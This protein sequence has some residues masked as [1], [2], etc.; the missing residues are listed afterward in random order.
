VIT[1]KKGTRAHTRRQKAKGTREKG[2][3]ALVVGLIAHGKRKKFVK[4]DEYCLLN[5][6]SFA[7]PIRAF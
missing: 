7:F 3:K 4:I 1:Y 6:T 2:I 5:Q